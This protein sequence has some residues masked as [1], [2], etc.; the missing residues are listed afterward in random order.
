MNRIG[1]PL[2]IVTKKEF[3]AY[4]DHPIAYIIL[5]AFL[6]INSFFFF[7]SAFLYSIADIRSMF[8][9]M[10][11]LFLFIVPAITMRL[12]AEEKQ[13]HTLELLFVQPVREWQIL[14]GKFFG[15]VAFIIVALAMTLFVPLLL[16]P[17][18]QFDWGSIGAQ[19]F[20]ALMLGAAMSAI[21]IFSSSLT[22]NQIVAFIV[23]IVLIFVLLILGLD[24]VLVSLPFFL[25][26]IFEQLS[27]TWHYSNV[28]RGVVDLRDVIYFITATAAFLSASYWLMIRDTINPKR[29]F[30]RQ[31]KFGILAIIC[32][33]V[34]VNLLGLNI[35]GRLDFTEKQLYTLS[36]ATK[37]IARNLPDVVTIDL[38]RSKELPPEVNVRSRDIGDLLADYEVESNGKIKI[39]YHDIDSENSTD[40]DQAGVTPVQFN[41]IKSDEFQIKRGYFGL[42]ISYVDQKETIPFI[43][44]SNNFEY[45]LTSLV[46]RMTIDSEVT[47]G[48]LTGHEE[49]NQY[50]DY[51]TFVS[52]LQRQYTITSVSIGEE[53]GAFDIVPDVL[54]IAGPTTPLNEGER[55]V[56]RSF[57]YSGGKVLFLVD[58]FTLDMQT[59]QVT[60]NEGSE[61]ILIEEFGVRVNA[62]IVGDL[63][64]HES[65]SV[66]DGI[67]SYILPY[68]FWPRM[69]ASRESA[70]TSDVQTVVLPWASSIEVIDP[71]LDSNSLLRT[72]EAGFAQKDNFNL[73]PD[74][75][76]DI[77][78]NS[79]EEKTLAVSVSGM[80]E[81]QSGNIRMVVVGDSDYLTENFI[82]SN[83]QA[84][85]FT[86]NAIDWLAQDEELISVR[87]KQ[88]A[89]DPLVFEKDSQKNTAKYLNLIG[90]PVF[91][92]AFGFFYVMR[93]RKST[94]RSYEKD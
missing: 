48:F 15:S 40:A 58:P 89:A 51:G 36:D 19:Y 29:A 63:Q 43:E 85:L 44:S 4:F 41:I 68:P 78:E 66:G 5:I 88:R 50:S 39:N 56:I 46:R 60:P 92:A 16:S 74:Q 12:I 80:N 22:K 18:G 61:T 33:A 53:T 75:Q 57:V 62:D 76:F 73:L 14:I 9:S 79:I 24:V 32:I 71:A 49:K 23:G 90:V 93:R 52:E 64:S 1:K 83:P 2:W 13:R 3:K 87:S 94:K 37:N 42:T 26:N 70:I 10:L 47:I 8:T 6:G 67:F 59:L 81:E 72:T 7:R 34:V 55:E 35:H 91:V 84:L 38:Y 45:R 31:L 30:W 20:G 69:I 27:L 54:V 77:P 25:K 82:Q 28:I 21:G 86:L 17:Y 65:I 11:W